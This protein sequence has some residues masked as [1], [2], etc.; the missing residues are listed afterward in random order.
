MLEEWLLILRHP[1]GLARPKM[2]Y[3]HSG[4]SPIIAAL[5]AV[6]FSSVAEAQQSAA[7]S[8]CLGRGGVTLDQRVA[9]CSSVI[10][11]GTA[12]KENLAL[13][14]GNRG[15]AKAFKKEM[16]GARK[17]FEES[18][19]HD[20]SSAASHRFRGNLHLFDADER[21]AS[22]E[23]RKAIEIDP[24][25]GPAYGNLGSLAARRGVATA[26]IE[27]LDKSIDLNPDNLVAYFFR[28]QVRIQLDAY[29]QA[30][31]DFT[32]ALKG[33]EPPERADALFGRGSAF[34]HRGEHE[35]ALADYNEGLRLKND[36]GE[37]F[38]SRC[39]IRAVLG[40]P[41]DDVMEDCD[42]ALHL[43]GSGFVRYMRG[44]ALLRLGKPDRAER[45]FDV[46]LKSLPRQSMVAEAQAIALYGRGLAKRRSGD[47][48]ESAKDIELAVK[49]L[50]KI[51]QRASVFFGVKD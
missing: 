9:A 21:K 22:E 50:P 15:V 51:K 5:L 38:S 20:S 4:Y 30:I 43:S 8:A 25:H 37:P 16:E 41:F 1:I 46:A 17:D 35:K 19:R 32:V 48:Q 28:G 23:Y 44:F 39:A 42:K 3:R 27:Y 18:V 10:E 11:A 29:D 24:K 33:P 40:Q 2:R 6:I 7:M 45:E 47:M 31:E 14:Y 26:A 36:R 12:T 34:A 49:L 13:A